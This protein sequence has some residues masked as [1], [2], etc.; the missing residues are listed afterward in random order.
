MTLC[1]AHYV[2]IAI[3]GYVLSYWKTPP[4]MMFMN[5]STTDWITRL[6]YKFA[7]SVFGII[8]RVLLLSKK[9]ASQILTTVVVPV[10]LCHRYIVA[11]YMYHVKHTCKVNLYTN[12]MI[13]LNTY[14]KQTSSKFINIY[15]FLN[16]TGTQSQ[17]IFWNSGS[18]SAPV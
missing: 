6:T 17:K 8:T 4:L 2:T 15:I 7:V 12:E 13:Y 1:R 18:S 14:A 16:K 11:F 3:W 9:I 5:G 10:C